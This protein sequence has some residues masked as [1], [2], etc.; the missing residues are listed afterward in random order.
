VGEQYSELHVLEAVKSLYI[1]MP[2]Y[3][4]SGISVSSVRD[5]IAWNI[6]DTHGPDGVKA[7][8]RFYC[9]HS[10]KWVLRKLRI[11]SNQGNVID[12]KFRWYLSDAEI[13][14]QKLLGNIP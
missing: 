4:P 6:R 8:E 9:N 11:L 5:M 13:V 12:R 7:R 3:S 10:N 14:A 2:Q 1:R